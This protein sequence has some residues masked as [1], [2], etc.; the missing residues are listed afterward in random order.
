MYTIV[1]LG[2]PGT[3]YEHTRHNVGWI[4]LED[5][6][7]RHSLP[8]FSKSSRYG[9]LLSEG[10]L[11]ETEVGIL[12]PTTFMN[13]SG[14]PTAKYIKENNSSTE[15]LIV[16]HDDIDLALGEVKVSFDR[17]AGGHN[18]VKSIID[19]C[20]MKFI[21]IRVGIAPRGFFGGI[22]RPTGEKLSQY[23]L[24]AFR[25]GE[26]KSMNAV[27]EKVDTALALILQK[28][29]ATAMQEINGKE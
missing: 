6:V 15:E 17:G 2:N 16:V 1:G 27:S 3:E 25:V 28:G 14:T 5:I 10:M 13:N 7:T 20:G 9:G 19:A 8:S 12:L 26:L 4:I 24:G 23:V 11:H 29:V 21:R 18:G 22:K